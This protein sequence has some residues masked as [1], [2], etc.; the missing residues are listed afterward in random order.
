MTSSPAYHGNE[1]MTDTIYLKPVS[2][3]LGEPPRSDTLFGAICWAV[4][5]TEGEARLEELLARFSQTDPPFLL[6]SSFPAVST[7]G[8]KLH[9][10]PVPLTEPLDADP[11]NLEEFNW[12]KR[13]EN[14]EYTTE[15]VYSSILKGELDKERI[16][17]SGDYRIT[18]GYLYPK[19]SVD[20]ET[21]PLFHDRNVQ[22]TTVDRLTSGTH[23]GR[24]FYSEETR[25]REDTELFFLLDGP[26]EVLDSIRKGLRFLNDRGIGGDVSVGKG[27][28]EVSIEGNFNPVDEPED[29]DYFT[30]LSL[31]Y[32]REE[33]DRRFRATDGDSW[34]RTERRRGRLESSLVE[35]EDV[36]KD[37]VIVY[38]EGSVFPD[39]GEAPYGKNPI[40]KREPFDVQYYGYGYPVRMK[41]E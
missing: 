21:F 19:G 6:T 31:F 12:I 9:F 40:V 4:K 23:E 24:L 20:S 8:D 13:V 38:G 5:L 26:E 39:T 29:G 16:Y 32:P 22:R 14:S 27:E 30:N 33:N 11:D 28:F 36:W 34:F 25:L 10:F 1:T 18:S 3:F 17:H 2:S 7:D 35:S 37:A 41:G 15:E